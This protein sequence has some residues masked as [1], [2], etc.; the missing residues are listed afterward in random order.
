MVD[1]NVILTH[2]VGTEGN[3]TLETTHIDD[4]GSASIELVDDESGLVLSST[5]LYQCANRLIGTIP[6]LPQ[7]TVRYRT[8]GNDVNGQQFD[9]PSTKTVQFVQ[10][11]GANFDLEIYGG[12]P[13]EFEHEQTI[14]LNI[15]VYN[16]HNSFGATQYTFT[17]EPVAN[18]VQAFRPV[19]LILSPGETGFVTM[20]AIPLDAEPG[21]YTFTATVTDDC[22]THSVSKDI[23]IQEPERTQHLHHLPILSYHTL[24]GY[25]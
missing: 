11:P 8:I 6:L 9:S 18:F 21:L 2:S 24:V 3:V 13:I 23:L 10:D 7:T 17:F 1:L 15:T 16:H 20:I 14:L 12:N 19:D 4:I 22:V 25:Y 5:P